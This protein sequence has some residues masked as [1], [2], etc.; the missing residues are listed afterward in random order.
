M[1]EI[2]LINNNTGKTL[3]IN[4]KKK[5]F[6]MN[7][8][9][10]DK[11]YDVFSDLIED[12]IN[13]KYKDYE[14]KIDK[15]MNKLD[16]KLKY[17]L[18][19]KQKLLCYS[20]VD[21]SDNL[22]TQIQHIKEEINFLKY[23]DKSI[24][25]ITKIEYKNLL[26]YE[27]EIKGL[28]YSIHKQ[29]LY[30]LFVEKLKGLCED[31]YILIS[32]LLTFYSYKNHLHIKN[33]NMHQ[34]DN[35]EIPFV[36]KR[37]LNDKNIKKFNVKYLDNHYPIKT[38]FIVQPDFWFLYEIGKTYDNGTCDRVINYDIPVCVTLFRK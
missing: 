18:N 7:I 22:T 19:D 11:T 6:I 37:D 30:E 1:T 23:K 17:T 32:S 33:L 34:L 2:I 24:L 12:V 28:Y 3:K 36:F 20:L 10:T 13:N 5:S 14:I 26:I 29:G 15:K 8:E 25:K 21:E 35:L 4:Y 27:K 16:F 31:T 9:S 38:A